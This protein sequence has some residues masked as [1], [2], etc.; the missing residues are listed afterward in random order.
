MS[1][2][3]ILL[4]VD[5]HHDRAT[6]DTEMIGQENLGDYFHHVHSPVA[7]TLRPYH[8]TGRD[9]TRKDWKAGQRIAHVIVVR[10][11]PDLAEE[12]A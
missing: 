2:G 7:I 1:N 12:F 6:R 11:S 8:N 10:K 4:D 9:G 3:R 5:I